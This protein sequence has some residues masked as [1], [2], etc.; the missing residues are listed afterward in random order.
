VTKAI[1]PR[2]TTA[3]RLV[4]EALFSNFDIVGNIDARLA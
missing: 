4:Y 3:S 1:N 2:T